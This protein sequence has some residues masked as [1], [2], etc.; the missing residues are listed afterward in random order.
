MNV[1]LLVST[2]ALAIAVTGISQPAGAEEKLVQS[3]TLTMKGWKIAFIG[4]AGQS[5]GT[6]TY[7][8]KN[9]KFEMTGL[10]IGGLG[11][12]TSE[13][14]G[15]V[16]DMKSMDD[17]IGSY[18]SARSGIT[19]GDDEVIKD[20]MMWL[21]NEKGVSIKLTTAKDGVELNLG[22][23]GSVIKWAD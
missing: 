15:V 18:A 20:R 21:R 22:A 9:R 11:I 12:S 6:L 13:A 14:T 3:A 19:L 1:R 23:D 4:S 16:Y 17:F 7:Q 2:V 8:G 10:G 5:K